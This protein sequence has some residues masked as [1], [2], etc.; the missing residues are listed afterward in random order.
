M[1][2]ISKKEIGRCFKLILKVHLC[3]LFFAEFCFWES[4]FLCKIL[5]LQSF[6]F[7]Q[8]LFIAVFC[9]KFCFFAKFL[10][11][12]FVFLQSF[13][14]FFLQSFVFSFQKP[15]SHNSYERDILILVFAIRYNWSPRH[16]SFFYVLSSLFIIELILNSKI[17]LLTFCRL[18][19]IIEPPR[20]T[21]TPTWR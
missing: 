3:H 4:F 5:F 7:C 10:V 17:S 2:T 20:R 21:R 13:N 8:V 16:P 14:C 18:S 15:L 9:A 11:Q 6:I 19:L 1:S 12:T